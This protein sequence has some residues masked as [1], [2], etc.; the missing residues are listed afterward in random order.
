MAS[1]DTRR[2]VFIDETVAKTNMARTFAR[3]KKGRR[4]ID[5]A[6]HGHWNTTTLVAGICRDA[7]LAPMVLDGPMD[8]TSFEAYIAQVRIPSLPRRA[9][10][11]MDNLSAHK[12]ADVARLLDDAGAELWYLPAY[13]PDL[14]PIEPMWSKVKNH[15]RR[16]KARTQ[17]DLYRAIAAAL[18][19]IT[20]KDAP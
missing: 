14:N 5:Y 11:V 20:A 6:T 4:A 2:P 12:S 8:A 13:S 15:L 16:V 17:E 7:A 9:I 1:I 10:V 18:T 19:T 3:A